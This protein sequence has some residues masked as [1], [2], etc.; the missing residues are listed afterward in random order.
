MNNYSDPIKSDFNQTEEKTGGES[1]KK[2]KKAFVEPNISMP[3]EVFGVTKFFFQGGSPV[4]DG[5]VV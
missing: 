3:V 2:Q 4:T 1:A 5:G